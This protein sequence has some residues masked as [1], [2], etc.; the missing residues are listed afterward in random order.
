LGSLL[1]TAVT[2]RCLMPVGCV[3]LAFFAG[4]FFGAIAMALA[5]AAHDADEFFESMRDAAPVVPLPMGH[6][7]KSH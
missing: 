7:S 3:I 6:P 4:G 2:R 5:C 1:S